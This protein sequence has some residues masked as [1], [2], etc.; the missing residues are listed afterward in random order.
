MRRGQFG[1]VDGI[2]DGQLRHPCRRFTAA[3]RS[4]NADDDW[5]IARRLQW[6]LARR[7][8]IGVSRAEEYPDFCFCIAVSTRAR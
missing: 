6:Y 7:M 3:V 4:N 2:G 5:G 8:L 1:K